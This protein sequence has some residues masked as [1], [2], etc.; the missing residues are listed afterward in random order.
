MAGD[1]EQVTAKFGW[2]AHQ[3]ALLDLAVSD[4]INLQPLVSVVEDDAEAQGYRKI[5]RLRYPP[6]AT[7][8]HIVSDLLNNLHGALDHLAWQL[9][10]REGGTPDHG[11]AFPIIESPNQDG[12]EPVVNIFRYAEQGRGRVPLIEDEAMLAVLRGVQPYHH[13]DL[14]R[15]HPL[16]VLRTINR[17]SKHRQIPLVAAAT[18]E[19]EFHVAHHQVGGKRVAVVNPWLPP[20]KDGDEIGWFPYALWTEGGPPGDDKLGVRVTV[21]G[22]PTNPRTGMVPTIQ[23]V[24][25]E[26]MEFVTHAILLPVKG[27]F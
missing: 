19:G 24:T 10:L 6:P 14:A 15:H 8:A 20:L 1:F 26:L 12:S 25:R 27:A 2:A 7:I 18:V 4:Y 22:V 21:E 17:E 5:V 11:T 3:A 9:A 23:T 13:G 16:A